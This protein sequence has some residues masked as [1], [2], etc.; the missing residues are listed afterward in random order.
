MVFFSFANI[1]VTL[2]S[3]ENSLKF[4]GVFS[5]IDS[6]FKQ[7]LISLSKYGVDTWFNQKTYSNQAL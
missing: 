4:L 3:C 2:I 7:S 5:S 1:A 6:Y